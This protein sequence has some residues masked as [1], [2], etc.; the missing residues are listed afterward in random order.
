MVYTGELWQYPYTIAT[1]PD[2]SG[3][4]ASNLG[5]P[6]PLLRDTA[7]PEMLSHITGNNK[8]GQAFSGGDIPSKF[9]KTNNKSILRIKVQE[10]E[11]KKKK[12]TSSDLQKSIDNL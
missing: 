3:S 5:S 4:L 1:L 2:H 7:D 8:R 6:A 11:K 9:Q 12:P 10:K